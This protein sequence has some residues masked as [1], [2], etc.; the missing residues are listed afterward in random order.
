MKKFFILSILFLFSVGFAGCDDDSSDPAPTTGT[1]VVKATYSGTEPTASGKAPTFAPGTKVIFVYVYSALTNTDT[2]R[3]V[4]AYT[5]QTDAAVTVGTEY[6]L[7]INNV[8]PGDYKVVAFYDYRAGGS[9]LDSQDDKF[10]I[11][12]NVDEPDLATL[13][14]VE[15]GSTDE[16]TM[17][18]DGL[19]SL[20]SSAYFVAQ[21]AK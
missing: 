15:A 17:N 21:T 20:L 4:T 10:V 9:N 7:T 18:I 12:N 2:S 13:V 14:T 6:T 8:T 3:A 19:S 1:I 5:V 16:L 11:Y